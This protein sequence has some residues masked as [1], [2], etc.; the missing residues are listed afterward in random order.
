MT[1]ILMF[2]A[3]SERQFG[4]VEW[5]T[6]QRTLLS[7]RSVIVYSFIFKVK[8]E[9]SVP[10][11]PDDRSVLA[12]GNQTASNKNKWQV[13]LPVVRQ[14][15]NKPLPIIYFISGKVFVWL[16]YVVALQLV[17][18]RILVLKAVQIYTTSTLCSRDFALSS[19]LFSSCLLFAIFWSIF[20]IQFP[21][22]LLKR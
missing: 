4:F 2:F 7:I 5:K 8:S 18:A 3:E 15:N 20:D 21:Q 1:Q 11:K 16:Q 14:K 17:R 12:K 22:Q 9:E 19:L 6:K 13:G 10:D